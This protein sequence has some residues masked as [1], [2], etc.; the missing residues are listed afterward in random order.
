[1]SDVAITILEEELKHIRSQLVKLNAEEKEALL[2][3]KR[4][5]KIKNDGNDVR[6]KD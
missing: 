2:L 6:G 1:M 5:K 3:L 4:L